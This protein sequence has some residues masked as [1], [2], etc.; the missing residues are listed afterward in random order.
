MDV[1]NLFVLDSD[2]K[3][4]GS[5]TGFA[6]NESIKSVRYFGDRAYVITYKAID[7][8]FIIDLS[9]P[10]DPEIEGEVMIDGF[11]T[12]LIP[13]GEGRL[14]GIGHATGDNGYGG[15]FE[16]GL[17]IVLFDISDP[18]EPKVLDS[19]EFEEMSSF[20]QSDHHALTI[21]KEDGWFAVPYE[22]Y[23]YNE[24]P[25]GDDVIIE[26]DA[27]APSASLDSEDT[28][29]VEDEPFVEEMHEAGILVFT[30]DDKFGSIDQHKLDAAQLFRSVYIGEWIYALDAKGEVYSFKPAL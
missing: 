19:K 22:I 7:P 2:L 15:E 11:S 6:R 30:A 12:L 27:E 16:N 18:A 21:N 4:A 28:E 20:A 26:D 17:K 8:L 1:N 10:E 25:D 9:D 24:W 14:L 23:R 3:E 5:V 29:I 13:A